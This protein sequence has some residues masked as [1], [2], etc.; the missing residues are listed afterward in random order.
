[1]KKITA[2]TI[3]SISMG[4][5]EAV[6]VIYLR[7]IFYPAGFYFPLKEIPINLFLVEIFREISTIIMLVVISVIA[8]KNLLERFCFFIYSF[9]IWDIFY[10]I[11]LKVTL[12]WPSSLLT[13]DILFLIPVPWIAPVLAPVICC[14]SMVFIAFG[15][16]YMNE[17]LD[18]KFNLKRF[19]LLLIFF[20]VLLVL[21]S[22]INDF[23][24]FIISGGNINQFVPTGYYW[25]LL[26]IGNILAVFPFLRIYFHNK[27][28]IK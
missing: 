19:D 18:I 24:M 4:F 17:K 11:W 2:L 26:I 15:C 6:V 25:F 20:G 1:M 12:N 10:Y 27:V 23:T 21:I 13:Y 22:F 3:F 16:L 5:L 8:G 7:E 9:A 14:F 28:I